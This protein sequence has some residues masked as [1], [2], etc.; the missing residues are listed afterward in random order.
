MLKFENVICY[1]IPSKPV[2]LSDDITLSDV[3]VAEI[4][5]ESGINI[6]KIETI[7]V[8]EMNSEDVILTIRTL[9]KK[10]L[11]LLNISYYPVVLINKIYDGN[12]TFT[13][14]ISKDFINICNKI[15]YIVPVDRLFSMK[16]YSPSQKVYGYLSTGDKGT[17]MFNLVEAD[18]LN[19]ISIFNTSVNEGTTILDK[20]ETYVDRIRNWNMN[21]DVIQSYH[22][23]EMLYNKLATRDF[24]AKFNETLTDEKS[25]L[26]QQIERLREMETSV[27][28]TIEIVNN[29]NNNVKK[30][31]DDMSILNQKFHKNVTSELFR[32]SQLLYI[33]IGV[34]II[35][36]IMLIIIIII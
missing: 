27:I 12:G 17:F 26:L 34:N 11:N 35:L 7:N 2:K 22:R 29:D 25:F 15:K 30:T 5:V 1:A 16:H 3:N 28:K 6:F 21:C 23:I 31:L 4:K 18:V 13:E 10:L 32:T 9:L 20:F 24:I 19:L 8:N 14:Y 33:V 36:F